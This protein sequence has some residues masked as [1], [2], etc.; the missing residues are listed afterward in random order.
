[1]WLAYNDPRY[2]AQRHAIKGCAKV[3]GKI[4]GAL[5]KFTRAAAAPAAQ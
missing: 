5:A 3:L 2:L 1:V 4:A